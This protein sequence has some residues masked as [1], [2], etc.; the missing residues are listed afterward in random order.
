MRPKQRMRL[1]LLVPA[2]ALVSAAALA[3]CRTR[4]FDLALDDGG[5]PVDDS[6]APVDLARDLATPID[7]PPP[8]DFAP[9][10]DLSPLGCAGL[11]ACVGACSP[12]DGACQMNCFAAASQRAQ[13]MLSNDLNC[14]ESW[15]LG[16]NNPAPAR[17][18]VDASGNF[19]DAPNVPPGDCAVCL[20]NV[21]SALFNTTCS[22]PDDNACM[23][24]ACANQFE[25]CSHS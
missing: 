21:F 7:F 15:C 20:R 24:T 13:M 18:A 25:L 12:N 10:I 4:P 2:L 8:I 1:K 3:A 22:P 23:P 11:A 5:V 17:C 6:G 14:G 19:V 9:P 16:T